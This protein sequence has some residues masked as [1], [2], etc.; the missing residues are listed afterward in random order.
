MAVGR[1]FLKN[2]VRHTCRLPL[3]QILCF[4]TLENDIVYNLTVKQSI[5][6]RYVKFIRAFTPIFPAFY[7]YFSTIL[8]ITLVFEL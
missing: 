5:I 6:I 8:V 1:S 3:S 2:G 4:I 7:S